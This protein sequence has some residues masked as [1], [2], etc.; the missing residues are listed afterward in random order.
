MTGG[1]RVTGALNAGGSAVMKMLIAYSHINIL[2]SVCSIG[3]ERAYHWY[4]N[5][6]I[7][8]YVATI[9]IYSRDIYMY[10]RY[11]YINVMSRLHEYDLNI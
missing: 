6:V 2:L 8:E 3:E 7:Y 11:K 9:L 4:T 1:E 10:I 5:I